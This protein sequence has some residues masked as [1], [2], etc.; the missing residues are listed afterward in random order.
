MTETNSWKNSSVLVIRK[1]EFWICFVLRISIFEFQ[2]SDI[3]IWQSG[4]PWSFK[5]FLLFPELSWSTLPCKLSVF[6]QCQ[7]I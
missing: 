6:Q 7:G 2:E 5:A 1:F 3:K 4:V